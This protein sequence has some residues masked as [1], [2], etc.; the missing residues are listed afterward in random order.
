MDNKE[1]KYYACSQALKVKSL[2]NHCSQAC[3]CSLAPYVDMEEG[4]ALKVM[5][6][7]GGG[8]RHEQLCGAVIAAGA[9]LGLAFGVDQMKKN[10]EQ[11]QADERLGELTIEFVDRFK[12]IIGTTICG[13]MLQN[14]LDSFEWDMPDDIGFV[15]S[16]D[17][18]NKNQYN[19]KKP[20]CGK[21]IT[22]ATEIALDI[23]LREKQ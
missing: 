14:E 1:K 7:L 13:E 19:L 12:A 22:S 5:A 9:A 20:I 17:N 15:S 8:M 16:D 11:K 21:A 10:Q 2:G 4:E 3:L 18:E 6:A 23:I